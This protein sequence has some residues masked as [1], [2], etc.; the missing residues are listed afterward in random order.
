MCDCLNRFRQINKERFCDDLRKLNID[1]VQD[2][3]LQNMRPWHIKYFKLRELEK[4]QELEGLL[5]FSQ[6]AGHKTL[7]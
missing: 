4:W 3:L 6:E 1:G 2:M 7:I 5:T